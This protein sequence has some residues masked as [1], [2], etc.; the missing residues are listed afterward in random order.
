MTDTSQ[1]PDARRKDDDDDSSVATT[2]GADDTGAVA[3]AALALGAEAQDVLAIENQ[4]SPPRANPRASRPSR[5]RV[6]V[7]RSARRRRPIRVARARSASYTGTGTSTS[8]PPA[9]PTVAAD[10]PAS[11]NTRSELRDWIKDNATLLSNASLLI[12]L[13]A[14]ALNL[15][16]TAGLLDPYIKALIFGA[17][18]LLLVELHHQWPEDLQIHMLSKNA[19]P[20]NHSWRMTAFAFLMQFATLVFAVW[21]TLISPIILFPLA[22]IG[23]VLAFRQ[24]Y[25][26]R[27]GGVFARSF[28]I[29]ALIAVLL[30]TELLMLTVWAVV[31][32]Q[33]VTI[34]LF[35]EERPGFDLNRGR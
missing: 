1:L 29:L 21:A 3:A 18:L 33:Q 32:G 7:G 6:V 34:E 30:I 20:E 19:R 5:R 26:R 31:T 10:K 11:P 12:S 2:N 25:F 35:T 13:A 8:A 9:T 24:W 16:P 4:R 23:V 27:F 22:A 14:V 28:G 15:L 17:A